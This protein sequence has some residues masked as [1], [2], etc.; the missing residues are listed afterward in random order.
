[1]GAK[2]PI[3]YIVIFLALGYIVFLPGYSELH[4]L[5]GQNQDYQKRIRLLQEQNTHLKEELDMMKK[6][7]DYR[8]KRAREKLGMVKK[9]EVIYKKD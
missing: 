9:G 5:K 7:P 3:I 2:R 4:K 1:M 8:E 6:S